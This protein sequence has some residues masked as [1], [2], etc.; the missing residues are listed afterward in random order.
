MFIRVVSIWNWFL[1]KNGFDNLEI[2]M[3]EI[4]CGSSSESAGAANPS[5]SQILMRTTQI[6][7]CKAIES[8]YLCVSFCG[9]AQIHLQCERG[10]HREIQWDTERYKLM[11]TAQI[12][13]KIVKFWSA[14]FRYPGF[15]DPPSS[16]SWS[17]NRQL[18]SDILFD[19]R[20][21]SQEFKKGSSQNAPGF[22]LHEIE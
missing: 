16:Q 9:T 10:G 21:I 8:L 4:C 2:L 13:L 5:R 18:S 17:A 12:H 7:I 3:H 11:R 22:F 14:Y 19:S 6:L 20:Y 15:A 1:K